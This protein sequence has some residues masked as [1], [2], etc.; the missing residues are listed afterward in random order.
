MRAIGTT[1][2]WVLG[3]AAIFAAFTASAQ[4]VVIVANKNVT[5]PEISEAQLRDIFIGSRS[6]LNDGT[7]VTPVL[8]KGGPAHEVFLRNHLGEDPDEFRNRWRK[9][10]FTGQGAMPKE[11][12]SETALLDYV[13]ATPGAIGYVS[14]VTVAEKIRVLSISP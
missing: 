11:F 10:V 14:R 13:A 7:R 9:A 12:S 3:L 2:A 5:L 8:L 6:R 1:Y 4:D